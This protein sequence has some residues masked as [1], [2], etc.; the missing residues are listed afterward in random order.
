MG[1]KKNLPNTFTVSLLR[2]NEATCSRQFLREE[3]NGA[4]PYVFGRDQP[5]SEN[6]LASL[7]FP[8][9]F[10]VPQHT[11][12]GTMPKSSFHVVSNN[13]LF[14]NHPIIRHVQSD[15]LGGGG[16]K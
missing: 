13:T 16:V 1:T 12:S 15:L 5:R 2:E 8:L 11:N 10:S 7:M 9:V 4:F 3:L 6:R 14:T